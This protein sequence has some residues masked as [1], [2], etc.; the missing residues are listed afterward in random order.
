MDKWI[1]RSTSIAAT[2]SARAGASQPT[3]A[4]ALAEPATSDA[5]PPEPV[6]LTQDDD[7]ADGAAGERDDD[8]LLQTLKRYWGFDAFRPGQR[9]IIEAVLR[10]NDAFVMMAT[11]SGKS[12]C[13]QLPALAWRAAALAGRGNGD[14]AAAPRRAPITIVVSPLIS[15]ME[16]QV[17]PRATRRGL[18]DQIRRTHTRS[19]RV[20]RSSTEIEP[21]L[22]TLSLVTAAV[23]RR[24]DTVTTLTPLPPLSFPTA[25]DDADA[26]ARTW[27]RA[28]R[29]GRRA[30]RARRHGGAHRLGA[31]GERGG[32]GGRAPRRALSRATPSTIP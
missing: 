12:L 26:A 2:S 8:V 5:P 20:I 30:R 17:C 6:D 10:G 29:A 3:A 25:A 7:A 21:S 24:A 32:R 14:D 11:G 4:T 19:T 31:G 16:D 13:Y 28:A 18:G 15:L 22:F 9:E 1:R 27:L 23:G